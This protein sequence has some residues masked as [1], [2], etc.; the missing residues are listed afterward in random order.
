MFH[1][2]SLAVRVLAG[3]N[4]FF[5]GVGAI[6][7][8]ATRDGRVF[9]LAYEEMLHKVLAAVG[10]QEVTVFKKIYPYGVIFA[11]ATEYDLTYAGCRVLAITFDLVAAKFQQLQL[12]AFAAEVD[13]LAYVIEQ[14]RFLTLRNIYQEAKKRGLNVYL[15]ESTLSLGSGRGVYS[16]NINEISFSDVPWEQSYEIPSVIVTGTNGKTTTVRLT[17]FI[18]Q[19]AGK[20]V[21]YCSTDGA[22][23]AGEIVATGDLSG[24]SGNRTVMTNPAVEVAVLEVARGGLVKRGLAT[25]SVSAAVVINV[26]EDHLGVNG[27]ESV[28]D[29]ARTKFIVHNAIRQ[30]GQ[31]I[32]NLDDE[33]SL[34][35]MAQLSHPKAVISQ[36][37][38][39]SAVLAYLSNPADYA[40]YVADQAFYVYRAGQKHFIAPLNAVDLTYKGLAQH[41]IEN[42]LIAICLSIELGRTYVEI[43][44]GLL[45]FINDEHNLGRFNFFAVH[46]SK[47]LVDYGHN[48]A[49]IEQML[50]FA[51]SIASAKT[52]ITLLLGFSGDRK[53]M[54]DNI[55][56]SVVKHNIDYVI[57]KLFANHLRGA[58]S[59]EVAQLMEQR[60]IK[61]G[62]NGANII[63][64]VATEMEA[65]ELVLTQLEA[66]HIYILLCQDD[67]A[68]VIA[69]IKSQAA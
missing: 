19:Y 56:Q 34:Q 52:K 2:N 60:L 30:G 47:I 4:I 66:E 8:L 29:L 7:E 67:A 3:D 51:R 68:G 63:A 1:K 15:L 58:E 59:G 64:T 39:E 57:L 62:F 32:I 54:I 5:A 16:A 65:L 12:P 10:W 17:S 50:K 45:A 28:L 22:V 26:S 35:F 14:E 9:A 69:K 13:Y 36:K 11:L 48:L 25:S 31:S 24:P 18:S 53:F 20:V 49:A 41:N 44:A 43:Q 21:G 55:A 6:M 42:V 38:S 27:I 23:V 37:L 46:Q 61:Q 40:A 33:L